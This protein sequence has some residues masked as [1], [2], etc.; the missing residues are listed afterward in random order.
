M[1]AAAA[2]RRELRLLD[3]VS[4][5][6]ECWSR[7][8]QLARRT[9]GER[10]LPPTGSAVWTAPRADETRKRPACIRSDPRTTRRIRSRGAE[11]SR[12][13]RRVHTRQAGAPSGQTITEAHPWRTE[14]KRW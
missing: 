11:G 6:W 3:M 7:P 13:A 8:V 5:F 1:T 2:D 12:A 10:A 14:H 9:W 4:P